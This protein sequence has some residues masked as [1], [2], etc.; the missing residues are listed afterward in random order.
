MVFFFVPETRFDRGLSP[1]AT[2]EPIGNAESKGEPKDTT[3]SITRTFEDYSSNE[4]GIETKQRSKTLQELN[5]WSGI[6]TKS[7][8]LNLFLRP[9]PLLL[10]PACIFATLACAYACFKST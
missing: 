7:N 6:D 9:F 2:A 8:Y 1:T 5:P 10:Y 3:R 4:S